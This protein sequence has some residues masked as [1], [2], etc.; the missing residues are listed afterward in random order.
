[1][2]T[3]CHNRQSENSVILKYTRCK[4]LL[5]TYETQDNSKHQ[6][7]L[8]GPQILYVVC[9]VART[10][11]PSLPIRRSIRIIVDVLIVAVTLLVHAFDYGRQRSGCNREGFESEIERPE[12][13][14]YPLVDGRGWSARTFV[15]AR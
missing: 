4:D 6:Y 10:D 1:M 15:W 2:E 13:I 7:P 9:G 3:L 5:E 12:A 14:R 11:E 8:I